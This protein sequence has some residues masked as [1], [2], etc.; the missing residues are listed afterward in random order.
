MDLFL[1][2]TPPRVDLQGDVG[3]T[4]G[5]ISHLG[6]GHST[7]SSVYVYGVDEV[8]LHE[9]FKD[10]LAL[11]L[12]GFRRSNRAENA[13]LGLSC[14]DGQVGHCTEA[15]KGVDP[16]ANDATFEL[17][18]SHR[19]DY[20]LN[21]LELLEVVNVEHDLVLE[22]VLDLRDGLA[23]RVVH[24]VGASEAHL[25]TMY[26][27]PDG[28][29]LCTVSLCKANLHYLCHGVRLHCGCVVPVGCESR[30]ELRKVG[31]VSVKIV[32]ENVRLIF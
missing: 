2:L 10:G 12:L 5:T 20:N 11:V 21:P 14:A 31:T 13:K 17:F 4:G 22:G 1:S 27:L 30:P 28:C 16:Q 8:V 6:E 19:L 15:N 32:R 29:T 23:G 18:L 25:E 7:A 3:S 26:D 9:G 24:N